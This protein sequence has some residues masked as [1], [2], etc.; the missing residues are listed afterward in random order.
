MVKSR[1]HAPK[2]NRKSLKIVRSTGLKIGALLAVF[3][4]LAGF[5]GYA[6]AYR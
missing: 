6:Y 1:A 4:L 5:A 3:V 2:R